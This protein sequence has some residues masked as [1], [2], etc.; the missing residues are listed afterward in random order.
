VNNPFHFDIPDMQW[1]FLMPAA[2]VA[3]TGIL[4]LVVE[5]VR[6]KQNQ[7]LIV[8]VSLGGLILAG[9]AVFLSS[10]PTAYST[11]GELF[12]HDPFG[13]AMQIL[14]LAASGLTVLFSETYLREK[15][16]SF[17]E[18]YPLVL[19]STVGAMMMSTTTNLLIIFLGLEILSV[20]LY[21][22]A[23]MSRREEKSEESALKYFLLGAFASGFLLYG[24]AF[25]YGATGYLD[26][27]RVSAAWLHKDPATH[28]MLLFGLSMLLIGLGFKTSL[29]PF[30]Q[31]T[32]DVYQGAPT[33]VTAFMAAASKIGAFAA[34][35]R[36]MAGFS[37]L[38]QYWAPALMVVAVLTMCVGNFAALVQKDIK[39]ILGYSSIANAGYMLIAILAHSRDS[40]L[41]SDS[42]VHLL[43]SYGLMT[44]GAFAVVSLGAKN[45][46]EGT[47]LED[48]NGLWKRSPFAALALLIFMASLIGIPPTA[49]FVGKFL[50]FFDAL[51][52]DMLPLALVLAVNSV[53]SIYYY[54]GIA[55][56]AFVADS[57]EVE[58]R[59]AKLSS[60]AASVCA[61]CLIGVFG[62]AIFYGPFIGT[63]M[64]R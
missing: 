31:W 18:F 14:I 13:T 12:Y 28:S 52:A 1:R 57:E 3:I 9:I 40:T 64:G 37:L 41:A 29:V 2:L 21:V 62:A 42:L 54:L 20:S 25:V 51:K 55:R 61:I 27:D 19:W 56:A 7:G 49:G 39:R 10:S 53:V 36:V 59:T 15:R 32:P 5:M 6:P 8:G 23:G 34:L 24:I 17:G 26:L 63:L 4:A 43:V 46:R 33:N 11:A 48:L 50:L 35:W 45:G 22:M 30:H 44:I 38:S 47:R 60:G 16:I 58:P